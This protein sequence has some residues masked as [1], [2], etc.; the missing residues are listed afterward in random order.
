MF[1]KAAA[2]FQR[3]AT[4]D[5]ESI[6]YPLFL[7]LGFEL[8]GRSALARTH[9]AL[10]ADPSAGENLLFAFGFQRTARP[11]SVP[12]KTVFHRL[13]VVLPN[14]S[15]EDYKFATSIMDARN[16]ELHSADAAFTQFPVSA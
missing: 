13:T 9:P 10:L 11:K 3:A 8:L 14:W 15:Q 4:F 7:T 6:E 2:Y 5:R 16:A 1:N 12:I